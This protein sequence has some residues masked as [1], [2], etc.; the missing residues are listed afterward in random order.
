[1]KSGLTAKSNLFQNTIGRVTRIR[2]EKSSLN[3]FFDSKERTKFDLSQK[4]FGISGFSYN[5]L[6]SMQSVTYVTIG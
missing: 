4:L 6:L 3:N 5:F 1:M 2:L